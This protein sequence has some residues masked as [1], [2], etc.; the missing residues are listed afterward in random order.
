MSAIATVL[1]AMGHRVSGS[2]L[3]ESGVTERLRALGVEWPSGTGPPTSPDADLLTRSTAV[4]PDN[5]EVA[6]ARRRGLPVLSRAETL[7][8]IAAAGGASPSPVP[9]ARPRP[10][11]CWP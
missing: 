6:E 1:H 10:P 7:A 2:D 4:G 5:T 3:R 8:A 11:R 9:T